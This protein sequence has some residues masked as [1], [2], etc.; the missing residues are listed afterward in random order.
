MKVE[1]NVRFNAAAIIARAVEE[2]IEYGWRRAHK[3]TDSPTE[4][5]IKDYLELA[6]LHKLWSVLECDDDK[7]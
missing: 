3:H 6:V 5:D 1:S 4:E 2:G 7:F